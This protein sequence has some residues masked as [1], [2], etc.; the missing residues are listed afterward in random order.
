MLK[1]LRLCLGCSPSV[2][3]KAVA[4]H[5]RRLKQNQRKKK[6][7]VITVEVWD[8]LCEIDSEEDL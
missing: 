5:V 4:A 6:P 1:V 3:V 8:R 7:S 2:H